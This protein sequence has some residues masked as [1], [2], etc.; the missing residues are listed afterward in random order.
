MR[1]AETRRARRLVGVAAAAALL[2]VQACAVGPNYVRPSAETP[3]AYKEALGWKTAEPRDAVER[4]PWWDVFGDPQLSAFEARVSVSNQTVATSEAQ[5]RQARALVAAARAAYFPTVTIGVSAARTRRPTSS[6]GNVPTV[7]GGPTIGGSSSTVQSQYAMP[8]DISWELDLWGRIRRSVESSAASAQASAA[9]LESVRLS[10][11]AALASNYFQLRALDAQKKLF[12]DT[13]TAFERSLELTKNR[14]A[15][16]IASRLDVAEA[17]TQL[18]T[19]R[20]LAIDIGVA[21]AQLEHAIATLVGAPASSFEIAF[22][23]IVTTPPPDIPTGVPSELLERRPD[24]A[25]A[26]RRVAS[27]NAQ[28]GVAESA[29][30]PTVTLSASGGFESTSAADWFTWPSRFWSVGPSISE[31]VFDGGLR[32]AQTEE[33][34]AAYDANVATYRASVL[35]GFQEVEDNLA[36]LRILDDERR[37]QNDAVASARDAV[38]ITTNQYKSGIVS[39]LNVVTSQATA[40]DNE[41]TAVDILGRRMTASVQ[42]LKALGGTWN[43]TDLPTQAELAAGTP[44]ASRQPSSRS[45]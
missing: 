16:G 40:L 6:I 19:T 15:G 36:A 10:L 42:L 9:D 12:D 7:I 37:V 17:Q 45:E 27:A 33:A 3:P 5:F 1:S 13:V 21:R 28:I 29:Y 23:P 11:Q 41:R 18:D 38:T 4:G 20:A 8:I 14:Y 43:A 24:V 31:T 2:F 35:T 32:G 25:A 22:A 30:F 39:Y 34:R 26:E 44:H